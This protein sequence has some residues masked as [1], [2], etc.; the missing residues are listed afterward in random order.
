MTR[1]WLLVLAG[2]GAVILV[3]GAVLAPRLAELLQDPDPSD[4]EPSASAVGSSAAVH[5]VRPEEITWVY[6]PPPMAGM[7][8]AS[9]VL[10]AGTLGADAPLVDLE[11][12]WK[13]DLGADLTRLPAI[14]A[15][16]DGGV[17]YVADD[18]TASAVHRAEIEL[19]GGDVALAEL[20]EVVWTAVGSPDGSAL[21][22]ALVDREDTGRDL[23]VVRVLLDGSGHVEPL[24]PPAVPARAEVITV[25]FVGFNVHLAISDDG[26]H[27]VRSACIGSEGCAIEAV[28]LEDGDTVALPDADVLGV[29]AATVVQRQCL[30]VGCRLVATDLVTGDRIVVG[31]DLVGTVFG[32]R[33]HPLLVL[34]D[35]GAGERSGVVVI[36]L[37]EG[38][39]EV[40]FE[41]PRG[42]F[43]GVGVH[44]F[45]T[46]AV[47]AGYVHVTES[48][49]VDEPTGAVVEVRHRELLVSLDDGTVLEIPPAPFRPAP[50][51]DVQ[52]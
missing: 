52:G 45:L 38:Q 3:V 29:A 14:S 47:P 32:N 40:L 9:Y 15:P 21:Y 31:D 28:D 11:V 18:G 2:S 42:A 5:P 7:P 41:A 19:D 27:L 13:A 46:L 50:G 49:P 44:S 51:F 16:I 1:R 43:A 39:R 25:A 48:T 10:Q 6:A 30:E 4:G 8:A 22:A 26:R 35:S 24:M 17:V 12:P 34:A 20:D 23:G 33:G 36:D 37:A